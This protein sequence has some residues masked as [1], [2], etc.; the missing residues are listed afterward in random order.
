MV[1]TV[2]FILLWIVERIMHRLAERE[3][4]KERAELC[5]RLQAGTLRDYAAHTEVAP[6]DRGHGQG[7]EDMQRGQSRS[8]E[9]EVDAES[10]FPV[11]RL[12]FSRLMGGD[13]G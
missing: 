10:E 7:S 13:E 12:A 9:A 4:H 11:A 1:V 6:T 2:G 5:S 3:W 8:A